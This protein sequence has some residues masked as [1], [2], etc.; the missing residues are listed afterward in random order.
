[1]FCMYARASVTFSTVYKLVDLSA[2]ETK[3][4]AKRVK[5]EKKA[6]TTEVPS[7]AIQ[8]DM[9]N[10]ALQVANQFQDV[11]QSEQVFGTASDDDD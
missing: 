4:K 2:G 3:Q 8:T 7:S 9:R 5:D 6:Y 1:M 11:K 10:I